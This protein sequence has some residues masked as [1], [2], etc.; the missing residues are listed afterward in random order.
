MNKTNR[1][2]PQLFLAYISILL[3]LL[4]ACKD[5]NN[6]I[7]PKNEGI[8]ITILYTNDEHGW[9]E[10]TETTEGAAGL[11]GLWRNK[12]GYT[13]DGPYLIL[14]GGDMWTGPAIS[15]WYQGKSM[16]EVMNEMQYDA[17][18]IGNHEFDFKIEE[19]KKRVEQ[20]N[21]PF[22]SANIREKNTG[23]IP[24]FAT[25]FII[26]K[27]E[28][29]VIG[30]I[31]LTTTS[32]PLTT[33]PT[34]VADY[35]FI[36]Y[37]TALKEIVPQAKEAGSELLI[38]I[39]HIC[40][41]EMR[42]LISLSN[43]LGISVIGG[44][45]CHKIVS[46]IVKNVAIIE[47]GSFMQNYSK[48]ELW[49]DDDKN[50]VTNITSYTI[51]NTG[52]TPDLKIASIV[53]KWKTKINSSLSEV[54]GYANK[55]I[56]RTSNEMY[57]MITDSWL[58]TFSNAD[59]SLTNAGGIR[60]SIPAGNITLETIVG[61][62]PFENTIVKLELTGQQ[63]I[64]AANYLLVG[65]MTTIGGYQLSDG[66]SIKTDITYN[67]LTTD[68]L[69]SRPD[70]SFQYDDTTPYE[71]SVHYRQPVIDWIKSLNTSID[72]PLNNYLDST[73]RK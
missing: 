59:V 66:T 71:T 52:A 39:G 70:Y 49:F 12:E 5:D 43:E 69:Y 28:G 26:K 33:F 2:A 34:H 6:I 45:H 56:D 15:T 65:G 17:A 63:L 60:Q 42:G 58:S 22:L 44:G 4:L 40:E 46:N 1:N 25:P 41:D 18:A 29:V 62:L 32:T 14:S 8:K 21:F 11:M 64:N 9:M 24:D 13:E 37:S 73:P 50:K 72:N 38:V 10:P 23:T 51:Q 3:F 31:G 30:I 35:K 20:S 47:S 68:Y 7:T 36:P 54:I 53:T 27:I 55:K 67:V 19:L 16:V 61:V 48:V 57:N